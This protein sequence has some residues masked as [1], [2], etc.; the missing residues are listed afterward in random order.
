[1]FMALSVNRRAAEYCRAQHRDLQSVAEAFEVLMSADALRNPIR[2]E[3]LQRAIVMIIAVQFEYKGD[4]R[5]MR[6]ITAPTNT[7]EKS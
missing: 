4:V 2:V 3:R 6:E 7:V 5:A 1:M